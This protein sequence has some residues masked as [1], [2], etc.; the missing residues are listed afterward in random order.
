MTLPST[1][2]RDLLATSLEGAAITRSPLPRG[3]RA[4]IIFFE[5][6]C[7]SNT[8]YRYTYLALHYVGT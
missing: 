4:Y 3:A 6:V 2:K 1:L 8:L 7:Y 5:Y